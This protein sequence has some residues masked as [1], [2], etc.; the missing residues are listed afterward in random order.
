MIRIKLLPPP[1]DALLGKTGPG[2]SSKPTTRWGQAKETDET[3]AL[4]GR[5]ILDLQQQKM[6]GTIT[7]YICLN[8][9]KLFQLKLIQIF[10]S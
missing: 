6:K 7:L 9:I 1:R 8:Q 5:G 2:A 4:D 3:R 10:I